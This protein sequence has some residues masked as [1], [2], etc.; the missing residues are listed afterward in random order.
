MIQVLLIEDNPLKIK[1]LRSILDN[2]EG[3][4]HY[5]VSQDATEARR[6]LQSNFYDLLILDLNIPKRIGDD[7]SAENSINLLNELNQGE[8]LVKPAN[9]IALTEYDELKIKYQPEFESYLWLIILYELKSTAW[10][11]Q[12][13]SKIDYL[14]KAKSTML[15]S[16]LS[17]HQYDLAF[18]T[19]LRTPELSFVLKLPLPWE[20]F[21]IAND[22]TEYHRAQINLHGKKF[23][24]LAVSA[25]QMGMA[26]SSTLTMKVLHSF[27]PKYLVMTGLAAGI[28]GKSNY[29]D[30]L[31]AELAFDYTS[32]KKTMDTDNGTVFQPDFKPVELSRDLL[33]D[34]LSCKGNRDFLD[35]I[36]NGWTGDNKINVSLELHIGPLASGGSVI[37]DA[38]VLTDIKQHSRKLIGIDMETY[39][40]YY[41]GNNCSKPKPLGVISIKSV[42]DFANVTKNDQCQ[43]YASYTSAMF[44]FKFFTEKVFKQESVTV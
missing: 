18:L 32:G 9:I 22:S 8:R 27:R 39:G 20:S 7:P 30:I 4:S 16:S 31:V 28:E 6:F 40:V 26:A 1:A 10:E 42:S 21:K 13:I 36:K 11:K 35:E 25:P 12:L 5:D 23:S 29:G 38:N 24:F 41:A 37:E 14:I 15:V 17:S 43:N 33:E 2:N 44:A 3:I 19:A 34:M